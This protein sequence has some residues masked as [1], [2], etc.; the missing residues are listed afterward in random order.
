MPTTIC[1]FDEVPPWRPGE[2][3][4]DGFDKVDDAAYPPNPVTDPTAKGWVQMAQLVQKMAGLVPHTSL[5]VSVD[6]SLS[7]AT[8]NSCTSLITG[9]TTS[10]FTA[11]ANYPLANVTI[12]W[13]AG[14]FPTAVR[15]PQAIMTGALSGNV[16]IVSAEAIT[17]GVKVHSE[18]GTGY[19]T[20][21]NFNLDI[22]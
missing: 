18:D 20:G 11:I 7:V 1:T 9:V 22:F 15:D 5:S 3:D 4:L 6:N 17:N 14:T 8:V 2:S 16:V 19:G 10:T 13:P 21:Q 12:T